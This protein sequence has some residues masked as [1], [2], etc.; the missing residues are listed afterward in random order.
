MKEYQEAQD[1]PEDLAT[2][3]ALPLSALSRQIDQIK[4]EERK[5]GGMATLLHDLGTRGIAY[6]QCGFDLKP[7]LASGAKGVEQLR[8]LPMLGRF[9]LELGTHKEDYEIFSRRIY[10]NVGGF[11]GGLWLETKFDS[12][13]MLPLYMVGGKAT[14]EQLPELFAIM[15]DALTDLNFDQVER[16]LQIVRE[17]RTYKEQGILDSGHSYVR[18]RIARHFSTDQRVEELLYG[19]SGLEFLRNLEQQLE[20]SPTTLRDQLQETLKA[21]F[22]QRPV[23]ADL[24]AEQRGWQTALAQLEQFAQKAPAP[25]ASS[26][27]TISLDHLGTLPEHEFMIAPAEVHYVGKGCQ[28]LPRGERGSGALF[29]ALKYLNRTY[30]WEQVRVKGGAYGAGAAFDRTLGTLVFSS[31][32]DK[33]LERTLEVYDEAAQ[34]LK[35]VE[36]SSSDF[37]RLKIG[38]LS[39]LDQHLLP[40]AKGQKVLSHYLRGITDEERQRVRDEIFDSTLADIRA[41]G[42]RLAATLPTGKVC[43]LGPENSLKR[44]EDRVGSVTSTVVL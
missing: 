28:L 21:I 30:L 32:R 1:Q 38:T 13:E 2:I 22:G 19:I 26:T 7:L 3:P 25:G 10:Q 29:V 14:Y 16:L 17:S 42:E 24:V 11:G 35:T 27:A 9:L 12:R 36:M 20:S 8:I 23:I 5:L 34:H 43:V 37:E 33:H 6:V 15:S 44:L 18:R 4:T 39:D 31:Y 41:L 40:D